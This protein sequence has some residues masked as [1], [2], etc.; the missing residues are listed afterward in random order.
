MSL[1]DARGTVSPEQPF[2]FGQQVAGDAAEVA[3]GTG[4]LD[5][6]A[7][8]R[9]IA[10]SAEVGTFDQTR[11]GALYVVWQGRLRRVGEHVA[12]RVFDHHAPAEPGAAATVRVEPIQQPGVVI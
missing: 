8:D 2:R 5:A 11:G 6:F 10:R 4:A 3:E 7:P 12:A 1:S 9:W